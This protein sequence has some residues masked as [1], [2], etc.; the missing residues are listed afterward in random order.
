MSQNGQEPLTT[1]AAEFIGAGE[2]GAPSEAEALVIRVFDSSVYWL[3][4]KRLQS[5][6][7]RMPAHMQHA[8]KLI[9]A[10]HH[11]ATR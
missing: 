2:A 4:P 6:G 7:Q 5:T 9:H 3:L 11:P 1:M 10:P 8:L